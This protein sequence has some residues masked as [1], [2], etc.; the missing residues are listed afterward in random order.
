MTKRIIHFLRE[1]FGRGLLLIKLLFPAKKFQV[2]SIYFH[3][4]TPN[5]FEAIVKHLYANSYKI[6]SL[7]DFN[8][9][10][11]DKQLNEKIAIITI[12]DGWRN[13]IELLN[14]VRKYK[15]FITI[16]I[17]TSA[18]EQ[19]NFW[20]EYVRKGKYQ[21]KAS[22]RRKKIYLKKLNEISFY[23]EISK[24]KSGVILDRSALT[25]DEVIQLSKEPLVTIG[26]HSVSHISLPNISVEEQKKELSDSKKILEMWTGHRI[27]YFAYPSGDYSKN[28]KILAQECGYNL[29][30]TIDP[31]YIDIEKADKLSIPRMCINDDAGYYEAL[32]KMYGIWYKLIKH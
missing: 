12:D 31:S 10:I 30:F 1:S 25:R 3:N 11:Q 7:Q 27:N 16:F 20:F 6:V 24:Y 23:K 2:L 13:N 26:S 9:L 22:V 29:C 18:I 5:L 19:G 17:T 15:V 21:T 4:P 32:S 28:L 8:N 14:I